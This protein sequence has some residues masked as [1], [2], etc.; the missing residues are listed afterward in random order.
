MAYRT[1]SPASNDIE[2]ST[3]TSTSTT[4]GHGPPQVTFPGIGNEPVQ[5]SI[6]TIRGAR[7]SEKAH[8]LRS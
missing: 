1:L 8:L 3:I 2:H 5:I 4:V 6:A 7:P